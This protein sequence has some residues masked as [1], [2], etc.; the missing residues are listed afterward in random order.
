MRKFH[1]AIHKLCRFSSCSQYQE[2]SFTTS[3]VL[4]D[5]VK[6]PDVFSHEA[7]SS[8]YHQSP[9]E[10]FEHLEVPISVAEMT[11]WGNKV[12]LELLESY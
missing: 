7:Q 1:D 5:V 10:H 4:E 11:W 12:C 3:S 6:N 8:G 9:P 2:I